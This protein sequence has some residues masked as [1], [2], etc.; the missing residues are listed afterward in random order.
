MWFLQAV[1]VSC[2]LVCLFV[3]VLLGG[4][5]FAAVVFGGLC[6]IAWAFTFGLCL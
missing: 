4:F 2:G 5:D 3:L 1:V 6:I